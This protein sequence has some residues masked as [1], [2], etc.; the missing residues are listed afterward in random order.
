MLVLGAGIRY[1]THCPAIEMAGTSPTMM[2][3]VLR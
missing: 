1:F 2:F 3:S